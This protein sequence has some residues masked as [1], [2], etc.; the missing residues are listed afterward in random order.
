M[1]AVVNKETKMPVLMPEVFLALAWLRLFELV[2]T[3]NI[4]WPG[5]VTEDSFDGVSTLT[6]PTK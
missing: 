6:V 5:S 3:L 4:Y 1:Y 2:S